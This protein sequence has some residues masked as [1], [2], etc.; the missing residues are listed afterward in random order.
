MNASVRRC[1]ASPS[2]AGDSVSR[3][4]RYRKVDT[5][6]LAS[7]EKPITAMPKPI[8]SISEPSARRRTDS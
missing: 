7:A 6:R 1:A 4:R 8:E 2:S 3:A 5:P